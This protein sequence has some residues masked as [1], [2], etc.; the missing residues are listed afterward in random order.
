MRTLE[1]T[2]GLKDLFLIVV[3]TVIGSG[4]FI[5]PAVV[6]RETGGRTLVALSVWLAAGVLSLLGALTYGELGAAHPDAGGLYVYLRDA[7]GPL[8]AFLFG[9]TAFFV[10]SSGSVATLAVAFTGYLGEFVPVSPLTAKFVAVLMIFVIMMINVRGTRESAHVQNWTTGIKVVAL[11]AMSVLLIVVGRN[12]TVAVP[13]STATTGAPALLAGFGIAMVA[14]LWAY[15]GWHYVS[16]S[17]GEARDPQRTFPRAIVLG[18]AVLIALYLLAN[19]AYLAALGPVRAQQT[20]RIA[21]DAVSAVFG[22]AA[23]SAIAAVILISMF[24]AANGLTITSPRM[25]YAMARDGVFFRKL[26]EVHPRFGTPA[27]AIIASSLWA[28]LLAASGTF[29]QL[30]TY[31]VFAGWI[32]YGLGALSIF[33]YRHRDAAAATGFRVPGY[34]L[35]PLLFVASAAAIVIDTLVTQPGRAVVG[36]VIV[37]LGVPVFYAWRVRDARRESTPESVGQ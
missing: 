27:F 26:A 6:L 34:P 13:A 1:R 23:G 31:V 17:A 19:I 2:L 21:A 32:F 37:L 14:V 30:L 15:E 8:P 9:W 28:M 16:F 29:E 36:L 24:S 35:T 20:D 25:Y 12:V 7:F 4:I 10:I 22:P 11:I 3:G 5:V 33:V 18:T